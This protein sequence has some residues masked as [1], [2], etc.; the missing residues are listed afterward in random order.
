MLYFKDEQEAHEEAHFLAREY[1]D[2]NNRL[3]GKP[4][5]KQDE[6]FYYY[7]FFFEKNKR[8]PTQEEASI[9]LWISKSAVASRMKGLIQKGHFLNY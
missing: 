2:Y 3:K 9:A 5:K 1:R 8:F 7:K 6:C 4:T